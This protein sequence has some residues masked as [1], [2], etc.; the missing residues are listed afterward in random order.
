MQHKQKGI[1]DTEKKIEPE[2]MNIHEFQQLL[3]KG[4]GKEKKQKI[5]RLSLD[6]SM[7]LE[8]LISKYG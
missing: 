2:S 7:Y 3:L 8:K 5:G 6:D 1:V 4:E